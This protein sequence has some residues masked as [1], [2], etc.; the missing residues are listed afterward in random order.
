MFKEISVQGIVAIGLIG[1]AL[2]TLIILG[3]EGKEIV[4]GVSG[5]LG[6]FLSGKVVTP[7]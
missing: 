5:V 3:V 6:G 1:I 4:I 7:K 2:S